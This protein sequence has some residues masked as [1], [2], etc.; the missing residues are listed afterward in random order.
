ML[1]PSKATK[2]AVAKKPPTKKTAPKT[3]DGYIAAAPKEQRAALERLRKSIKAAAPKATEGLSYGI[4]GF[5]QNGKYVVYFGSWKSHIALYGAGGS[6]IDAHRAELKPYVQ[7]KGT[8]QFPADKPIP[9][10]LITRI[11]KARVAEIEKAG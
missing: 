4:V 7:S 8:I 10:V 11:V 5:K 3:V 6:V 1:M 2:K 9:Y